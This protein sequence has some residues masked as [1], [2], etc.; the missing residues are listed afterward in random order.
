MREKFDPQWSTSTIG[1]HVTVT[2]LI[3]NWVYNNE[4]LEIPIRYGSNFKKPSSKRKRLE[5]AERPAKEFSKSEIHQFLAIDDAE[6]RAWILLG[7]N[8]GFGNSDLS[9]LK[10]DEIQGQWFETIRGKTGLSRKA[11]LW[12]ETRKALKAVL[13]NHAG[14]KQPNSWRLCD[15]HGNV[16][17]WCQDQHGD[18]PSGSAP[19]PI[20]FTCGSDCVIRRCSWDTHAG[21]YRSAFRYR[22]SPSKHNYSIGFRVIMIPSGKWAE[23]VVVDFK[24]V[25]IRSFAQVNQKTQRRRQRRWVGL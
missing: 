9:R 22:F 25:P 3:F 14:G 15:M 6:L 8:C 4:L 5:R 20:G 11:W 21:F 2:K 12:P 10:V 18:Y 17:E 19:D 24:Q 23:D 1:H 16:W 7:V 13:A